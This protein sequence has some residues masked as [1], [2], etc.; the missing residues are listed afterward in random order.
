MK[1]YIRP[2]CSAMV[3]QSNGLFHYSKYKGFNKKSNLSFII[4]DHNHLSFQVAVEIC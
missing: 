2:L 4:L 1:T 3:V